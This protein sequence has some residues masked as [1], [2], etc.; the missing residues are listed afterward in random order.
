MAKSNSIKNINQLTNKQV[1]VAIGP[2]ALRTIRVSFERIKREMLSDFN[3][4]PVTREIEG[5]PRST[6]ISGTLGGK[7]N[8]FSFIGFE[9]GTKPVDTIRRLINRSYVRLAPPIAGMTYF[10]FFLPDIEEVY[11]NTPMPWASGRSWAKGIE[12]G[13]SGLGQYAYSKKTIEDSRSGTAVQSE[14]NLRTA[15]YKPV[16]YMSAIIEKARN[17]IGNLVL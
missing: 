11:T 16:Q 15:N 13:M 1:A 5:G 8:L 2:S 7:G 9:S 17:K 3:S 14:N 4:H 6:N 12:T 10:E